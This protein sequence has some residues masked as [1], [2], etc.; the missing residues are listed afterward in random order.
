[1]SEK[2]D[3]RKQMMA[4]KAITETTGV[5]HDAQ[6]A[7]LKIW[8]PVLVAHSRE[9]E[10]GVALPWTENEGT[11]EECHHDD[12]VVEFRVKSTRGKAPKNLKKRFRIL[13]Q[14]VKDLLGDR[15]VVRVT[16]RG[17]AI[18]EGKG[19]PKGQNHLHGTA[20]KREG[21]KASDRS[22]GTP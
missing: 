8:G 14:S 5:I 2:N 19:I 22:Q 13:N 10:I 21:N 15:F 6:V 11:P 4:L 9:M 16:L 3:L 20:G 12:R 1:M 18:F 7:Q 17:K